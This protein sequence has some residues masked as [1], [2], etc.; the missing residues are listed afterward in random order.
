[1]KNRWTKGVVSLVAVVAVLSTACG[2]D[3][4]A[5]GTGDC[6]SVDAVSLQLQWVTQAQFAG[7]Y[8]AVDNGITGTT[9]ST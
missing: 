9:A 5:V 6:E 3:D 7:Y 1:M 2:S 4:A 8:A